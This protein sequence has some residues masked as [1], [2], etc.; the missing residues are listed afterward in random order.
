[1]N[2]Q[3]PAA[4]HP[5]CWG[6]EQ[7]RGQA[8]VPPAPEM[9]DWLHPVLNSYANEFDGQESHSARWPEKVGGT[10]RCVP[11]GQRTTRAVRQSP[12]ASAGSQPDKTSTMS[13]I[14]I[15]HR[16]GQRTTRY[17]TS[18]RWHKPS[19]SPGRR[20][21]HNTCNKNSRRALDRNETHGAPGVHGPYS[22]G[23]FAGTCRNQAI[24]SGT[25]VAASTP[26]SRWSSP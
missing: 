1:M 23:T 22:D 20:G 15:T 6:N 3:W 4:S 11:R 2:R 5:G 8:G 10:G 7:T 9:P 24:R 26:D 19:L 18:S 25:T 14:G 13:G 16:R 21:F 17:A 12:K